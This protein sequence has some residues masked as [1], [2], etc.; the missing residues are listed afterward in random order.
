LLTDSVIQPPGWESL[1]PKP[2]SL[3]QSLLAAAP[4]NGRV[5]EAVRSDADRSMAGIVGA[6][7]AD[8]N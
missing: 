3:G 7:F 4:S 6:T 5:T 1:H 8:G 2:G